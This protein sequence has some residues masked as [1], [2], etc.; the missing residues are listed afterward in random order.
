LTF[1][2]WVYVQRGSTAIDLA[3]SDDVRRVLSMTEETRQT[4]SLEL[5][6][7]V[8]EGDYRTVED[9]LRQ[10]ADANYIVNV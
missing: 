4:M 2:P 3:K 1:G 10:T 9:K 8:M 5:K 6:A 7:A